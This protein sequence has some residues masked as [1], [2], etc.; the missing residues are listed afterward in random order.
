[1]R[2]FKYILT[3]FKLAWDGALTIFTGIVMISG[4]F[5][6]TDKY[7]NNDIFTTC[8]FAIILVIVTLSVGEAVRNKIK[9]KKE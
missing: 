6:F 1:M 7:L 8:I 5:K 9:S 3:I 4:L 2:I